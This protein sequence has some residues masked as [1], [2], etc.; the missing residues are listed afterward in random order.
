MC[1]THL[2]QA[3]FLLTMH[4]ATRKLQIDAGDVLEQIVIHT[5]HR[6]IIYAE[7]LFDGN[8]HCNMNKIDDEVVNIVTDSNATKDDDTLHCST[9][10]SNYIRDVQDDESFTAMNVYNG[11]KTKVCD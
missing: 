11:Y 6:F 2:T 3:C 10:L 9:V 7:T 4:S 1:L 5:V 8:N